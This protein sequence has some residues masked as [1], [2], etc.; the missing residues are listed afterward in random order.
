MRADVEI[1][2]VH[3]VTSAHLFHFG[4]EIVGD[5]DAGAIEDRRD[6]AGTDGET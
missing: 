6:W 5:P 4:I 3:P 2:E 1:A